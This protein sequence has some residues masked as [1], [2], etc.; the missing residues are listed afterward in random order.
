M[1]S[2]SEPGN[3]A[4]IL[5]S[6]LVDAIRKDIERAFGI[7]QARFK[8]LV[9]ACRQWY[10]EDMEY[11]MKAC[12]IMHNMIVED[13][14]VLPDQSLANR[15]NFLDNVSESENPEQ[16][17]NQLLANFTSADILPSSSI[18]QMIANLQS[19]K[20]KYTYHLLRNSLIAHGSQSNK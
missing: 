18:Q 15:L 10:K 1:Q 6:K 13:E 9:E 2:L 14:R 4:E 5:F 19:V 3:E 20:N 16:A 8:I 7:L 11:I 12:I 17:A